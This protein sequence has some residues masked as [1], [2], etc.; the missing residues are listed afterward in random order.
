VPE[1]LIDWSARALAGAIRRRELSS[2]E[3]VGAFLDRIEAVDDRVNAITTRVPRAQVLA[4]ARE[5]DERLAAGQPVGPLHGLP[6][7]VKDLMDVAGLPTTHG[8]VPYR[9]APPAT[10]DSRLAARLR[11]AGVIFIGKTNT[12]EH[13]LGTLTFNDLFGPTRSPW[14]LS[15]NAGGSSGGAAAAVAARMLPFADGSDS[16]G[17]LRYPAAFCGVLGL[18]PSPGRVPSG[19]RG[20]GWSPHGV[21]GPIARDAADAG[22]LLS[23]MAGR[24]DRAPLSIDQDPAAFADVEA[25]PLEG[26]R[27]AWA[28]TAGGLPVERAVLEVLEKL[29]RGLVAAG[30]V[31]EPVEPE[32]FE[33]MDACW[34]VLEMLGF[35]EFAAGDVARHGGLMS[36]DLVRNVA[37]GEALS[38]AEIVRAQGLRTEIFRRT[39]ALLDDYDLL[40]TA[41]T[42][43]VS[44]PADVRW[45]RSVAGT[46]MER[47]FE[48]QRLAC[49]ITVTAHPAL[50]LPAGFTAGGLPV[51]VQLVGRHR[52]ELQL[53]RQAAAMETV[54]GCRSTAPPL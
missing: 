51:G 7:A 31:V 2:V 25:A 24:D 52:G 12:P 50:S 46:A 33:D 5:A 4:A 29:A 3:V 42:P 17:S 49:R 48:W 34:Q 43:V 19:R 38:A 35:Y 20:D 18:R 22:L 11:A 10:A 54:T 39:V 40:A 8:A 6:I 9:D 13:G 26:L 30:A 44:V 53:L 47:Y 28:P 21:L 36:A 27:I 23:A 45:P 16:G 37:E 32:F 14:D 15:A 1:Q 41:T